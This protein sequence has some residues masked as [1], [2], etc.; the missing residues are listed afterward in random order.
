VP[1]ALVRANICIAAAARGPTWF[2]RRQDGTRKDA[3]DTEPPLVHMIKKIYVPLL[4]TVALAAVAT[5]EAQP[6]Q[7]FR[8]GVVH[9][10]G[11]FN[12]MVDGLTDGLRE[13]GLE[14][15]KDV[16]L[17]I[18]ATEGAD[19][20]AIAESA[21]SLER[22]KVNLLYTL[23]TSLT[24]AVKRATAKIP[25]VF[26]I[27][28][29][30]VTAGLIDSLARPGGRLTGVQYLSLDLTAKRFE[31]LKEVLPN[32]HKVVTFY[33]PRNP[34]RAIEVTRAT[35]RT[36]NIEVVERPVAS[37]VEFREAFRA[38]GPKDAEAYFYTPDAMITSQTQFIIDTA[39][40]K[41]LPIMLSQPNLVEQG[42]LVAYGVNF[43]DVGHLSAKYVQRVLT[44]TRPERLPIESFSTYGLGVNLRT[45]RELGITIPPSV[46]V[47]ADKVVE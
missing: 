31:I 22:A 37:L 29:D 42:A 28:A 11:D 5:V 10:G 9:E 44:G 4:V 40:T 3:F 45:A 24:I 34:V 38:L 19:P 41:K 36:L 2:V 43:Y 46:V 27:G 25:I 17:D 20:A 47:R 13:L 15:G 23:G 7:P 8:I 18:R 21:Q 30:P 32:L 26:V 16:V 1:P 14:P 6:R 35:G 12:R 33:N 39:R